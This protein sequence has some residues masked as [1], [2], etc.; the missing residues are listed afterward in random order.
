MPQLQSLIKDDATRLEMVRRGKPR[1][2]QVLE[3]LGVDRV[4][5]QR[6]GTTPAS[7]FLWAR[8]QTL[9]APRRRCFATVHGEASNPRSADMGSRLGHHWAAFLTEP[10][11]RDQ[12]SG[13]WRQCVAPTYEADASPH[14]RRLVQS[15]QTRYWHAPP[16]YGV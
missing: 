14:D 16:R 15:G 8:A 3:V 13:R 11:M 6:H 7:L 4:Y 10:P 2:I 9:T 1:A 12:L 5:T